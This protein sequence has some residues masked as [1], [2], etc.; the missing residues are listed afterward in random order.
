MITQI[1]INMAGNKKTRKPY[2]QKIVGMPVTIRFSNDD[3]NTLKNLP[4]ADL[5]KL[6]NQINDESA[7]HCIIVRLNQASVLVNGLFADGAEIIAEGLRGIA[8]VKRRYELMGRVGMSDNEYE[9][10]RVALNLADQI[11]DKTTRREQRDALKYVYQVAA[12]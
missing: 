10:I 8:E 6:R 11:Q 12:Q 5:F 1:G 2:R 7:I 9:S 4:H 3:S